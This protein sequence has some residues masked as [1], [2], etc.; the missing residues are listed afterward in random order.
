MVNH[1][2]NIRFF[3]SFQQTFRQTRRQFVQRF[4]NTR[5][6]DF[7]QTG[8]TCRHRDRVTGKRPRL[9]NRTGRRQCVHHIAATA[10]C[11]NGHSATDDFTEAGQIRHDAVIILCS[12]QRYAETGH[13]FIDDQQCAKL[14]AQRTQARQE[15]RQRRDA[16]HVAGDRLNDDA[17]DLLRILFKCRTYRRE[18]VVGAGQG[19]FREIGRNA[20]GVRLA[21]R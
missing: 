9:V 3:G 19:V 16:V 1:Q 12:G 11:A 6:G 15:F 20:W 14:I 7:G 10:E 4:M 13:H 5:L 18:I 21:Q 17:G 8:I 2:R